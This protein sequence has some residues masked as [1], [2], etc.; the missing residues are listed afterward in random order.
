M[1]KH[2]TRSGRHHAYSLPLLI[3]LTLVPLLSELIVPSS[4]SVK[5][6]SYL[7][8]LLYTPKCRKI[9]QTMNKV[10]GYKV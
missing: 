9:Q 1:N 2:D 3:V 6:N 5:N 7:N 4:I 8:G 10:K